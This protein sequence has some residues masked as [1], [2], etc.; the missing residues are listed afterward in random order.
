MEP[1]S[2]PKGINMKHLAQLL[3]HHKPLKKMRSCVH[4]QG[5]DR[6][7]LPE[8]ECQHET[9]KH[10]EVISCRMYSTPFTCSNSGAPKK[11]SYDQPRQRV[12][13]QRGHFADEDPYSQSYG[14]PSSHV[15]IKSWTIKK[16]EHPRID[17][18][19]LWCW[20][21]LLRDLDCKIKPVHPKGNQSW[22]FI[23]RTDAEA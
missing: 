19:G 18:F 10:W 13:K 3:D 17:A 11:E 16:P 9:H 8:H 20:K 15:Q 2:G 23:G 21:K 12:K 4:Y 6:P 22:I 5:Q 1:I 14:F 7:L